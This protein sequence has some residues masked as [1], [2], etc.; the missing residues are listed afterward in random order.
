MNSCRPRPRKNVGY[1]PLVY[2]HQR[3]K[4]DTEMAKRRRQVQPRSGPERAFGEALRQVRKSRGMSQME[5]FMGSGID[6]TYIS[7]V[8]RGIQ[9]PTIRMIVRFANCLKVR[10]SEIVRRME[11]SPRYSTSGPSRNRSPDTT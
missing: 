3:A 7:A 10:P 8:E 5:L 4:N 9:S 6:R 11:Q 1:D 2:D